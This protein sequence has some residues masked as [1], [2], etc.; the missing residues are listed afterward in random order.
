M[1]QKTRFDPDLS[2]GHLYFCN[3][4]FV[5]LGRACRAIFPKALCIAGGV[6]PLPC[7]KE[8]L[9]SL[10]LMGF[11]T[12][13]VMIAGRWVGSSETWLQHPLDYLGE[14]LSAGASFEHDF[15]ENLDDIPL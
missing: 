14:K 9:A 12:V 7:I 15:V 10:S 8:L 2:A 3:G 6:C 1:I 5:D 13:V 11:A 4:F